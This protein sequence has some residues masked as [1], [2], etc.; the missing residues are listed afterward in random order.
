MLSEK[1]VISVISGH[2][3]ALSPLLHAAYFQSTVSEETGLELYCHKDVRMAV[4]A[5]RMMRQA[6][7]L[8]ASA[9]KEKPGRE[10]AEGTLS[11]DVF[12]V[13]SLSPQPWT[14]H[15]TGASSSKCWP[16]SQQQ[17]PINFSTSFFFFLTYF[18]SFWPPPHY[19]TMT[20]TISFCISFF[21]SSRVCSLEQ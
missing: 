20:S 8:V 7:V 15:R 12:L 10:R 16:K 13:P 5:W 9:K 14:H 21:E 17:L 18:M 19:L 4:P 11:P 2:H 6:A 1:Y 3:V